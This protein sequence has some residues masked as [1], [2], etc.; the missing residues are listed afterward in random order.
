MFKI[1]IMRIIIVFFC[2]FLMST[3]T[4]AQNVDFQ[5]RE[6][7]LK[8][9]NKKGR[10]VRNIVVQSKTTGKAGITNHSGICVFWDISDTDTL[11]LRMN[12]NSHVVIPVKG[13]DFIVVKAVSSKY[14]SYFDQEDGESSGT[15]VKKEP[16]SVDDHLIL[17]VPA[18][19]KQQS[20]S[21]LVELLRGQVS[22][23]DISSDGSVAPV[24]GPNSILNQREPLVVMDEVVLGTLAEAN[25][26]VN[27]YTIK[28]IE[29]LKSATKYGVRGAGGVIV[30]S[31]R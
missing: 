8:I 4:W 25:T 2:T 23:I 19:L 10:P 5:N 18:M 21:S 17:D 7:S 29:I 9:L 22:G 11:S 28:T 15:T 24:R 26:M 14:Y 12:N 13:M 16:F 30:I 1:F 3:F 6:I 27:I 20:F 31:T